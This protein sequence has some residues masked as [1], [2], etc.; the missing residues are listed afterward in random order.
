MYWDEKQLSRAWKRGAER[1]DFKEGRRG[2]ESGGQGKAK[3]SEGIRIRINQEAS[4]R[5]LERI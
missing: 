1:F 3:E 4:K 5:K 2:N